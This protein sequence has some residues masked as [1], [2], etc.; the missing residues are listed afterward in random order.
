MEM[1]LWLV[2]YITSVGKR[3]HL[4]RPGSSSVAENKQ[5]ILIKFLIFSN[6]RQSEIRPKACSLNNPLQLDKC[7]F[8][9]LQVW[10]QTEATPSRSWRGEVP[11]W[12]RT[13]FSIGSHDICRKAGVNVMCCEYVRTW[14]WSTCCVYVSI[15][16]ASAHFKLSVHVFI[17][18]VSACPL[19]AWLFFNIFARNGLI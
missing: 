14:I 13:L 19:W 16:S 15:F 6:A 18:C 11:V 10:L 7:H 3:L 17:M 1:R 4:Y 5:I 9:Q 8:I 2:L 12:D